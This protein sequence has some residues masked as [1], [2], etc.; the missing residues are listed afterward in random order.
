[1]Q[2]T[3]A[4]SAV[5]RRRL[6]A[7]LAVAVLAAGLGWAPHAAQADEAALPAATESAEPTAPPEPVPPTVPVL[8]T[9]PPE[10]VL[11]TAP[12]EPVLPTAP[13]EPVLPTAPPEAVPPTV[14]GLPTAPAEPVPPTVPAAPVAVRIMPLGDSITAGVGSSTGSGYRQV[15][16]GE[17]A[18]NGLTVD[19]VGSQRRGP[20]PDADHEGHPGWR[21][22]QL[23]DGLRPWLAAARPDVVLLDIGTNDLLRNVH[24]DSAPVRTANLID[25]ITRQLPNV[26]VVVAKLLVVGR[27][28]ARFQRFNAALAAVVAARG[29]RVT[30]VDMSRVPAAD[31]GD[32]VHPTDLGYR[33]M[34][35][36][37]YQALRPV[38]AGR[39]GRWVPAPDPFPLPAVR[40]SRPV[41][42]RRGAAVVL[43]G[44]LTARL[45]SGD[46]GRVPVRLTYRRAGSDRWVSM[47]ARSTDAAGAVIFSRR[48]QPSGY[49]RATVVS[50]RAAGRRSPVIRA[51]GR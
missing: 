2:H 27:D 7:G 48:P 39:A 51:A 43:M 8:P 41:A 1:V 50:G 3:F 4:T 22:D 19:F 38:L 9:A 35:Y 37:W 25:R 30:M 21:T 45:T 12:P 14:P 10:P 11:P 15:L 26:R 31:T 20:G 24:P 42:V 13:P 17:L 5:A 46:L 23:I 44:R 49:Y 34:A 33:Q 47:G 36:Q 18:A 40:L 16:R 28:A 29:P 32:G 6:R